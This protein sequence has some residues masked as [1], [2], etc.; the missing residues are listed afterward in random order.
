MNVDKTNMTPAEQQNLKQLSKK[1]FKLCF[2][3]SA[4]FVDF[5]FQKRY[6]HENNHVILNNNAPVAALQA[7]P[8]AMTF[9]DE[10][11]NLA[12]LSAICTH[13]DFRN[14]GLMTQL[15]KN[16][17]NQLFIDGV[18][19]TFLIPANLQLFDVYAKYDYKTI[20][21]R[22]EKQINTVDFKIKNEYK[23]SEYAIENSIKVFEYFTRKMIKRN[24]CIQHSFADFETICEDINNSNGMI[25]IAEHQ[26]KIAGI[27]CAIRT[28]NEVAVIEHFADND[29]I[30]QAMLKTVSQKTE[31]NYLNIV[32]FPQSSDSKCF[33]MMRIICVEKILKLYAEKHP[34]CKKNITVIDNII[35]ENN[36]CYSI[37]NAQCKKLPLTDTK[38]VW[39]I[40][41]LTQ[42][43]FA[44]QKSYMSLML[45]E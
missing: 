18:H 33:G 27:S 17:F 9:F 8:Y 15:L 12:Y 36:G 37:S 1:L 38:N 43:V 40:A 22:T 41:R 32:E 10:Q 45:N 19:A 7:I 6:T 21:Y 35:A 4:E 2:D 24:F 29:E 44:E 28:D 14:R 11:I 13:P 31:K 20:F 5:Y 25:L 3:D 23:I 16:T 26:N 34:N 30:L 39:D 42:F